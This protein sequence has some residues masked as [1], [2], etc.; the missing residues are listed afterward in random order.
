[1]ND[2]RSIS[3]WGLWMRMHE[4]PALPLRQQFAVHLWANWE[5]LKRPRDLAVS[6][7]VAVTPT[8][9][10]A[11]VVWVGRPHRRNG[12]IE[13]LA[14]DP[15]LMLLAIAGVVIAWLAAQHL[16]FVYSMQRWYAPFVRREMTRRGHPMCE[17]CGHRL[18]PIRPS[19]C[20]ECGTALPRAQESVAI[21]G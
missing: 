21:S 20:P 17:R 11:A 10:L 13:T 3:H 8:A 9:L 6:S 14:I 5:M 19:A 15:S 4:P 12:V 18:A 1:M 7:F 16:L 2:P